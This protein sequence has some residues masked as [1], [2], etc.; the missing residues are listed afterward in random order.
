[1]SIGSRAAQACALVC[2][3]CLSDT[4]E[5]RAEQGRDSGADAGRLDPWDLERM[6]RQH[7]YLPYQE[8]DLFDDGRAMRPVP[9]GAV[10]ADRVTDPAVE[11]GVVDGAYVRESPI[12]V[13]LELLR[14]GRVRFEIHCAPC[15][16]VAGDG[17]SQVARIM[18]LRRPPSLVDARVQSFPPGRI[19]EVIVEGYGLMR[20]YAPNLPLVDR[21][22]IVN[23]MRALGASRNIALDAL[24]PALRA[25]AAEELP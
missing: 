17:E 7:K 12:P 10:P 13:T 3:L 9:A 18:T 16:G 23:Y 11:R 15:H 25:R 5:L 24:P 6:L 2:L 19:Y 8:S 21:W 20:S 1:M 22:A 4:A 14:R